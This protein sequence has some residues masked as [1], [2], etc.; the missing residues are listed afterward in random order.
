MP[1]SQSSKA[2]RF[3]ELHHHPGAFLIPNPWDPGSARILAGLGFAALATSSGA[4]AGVHGWRD[5]QLTRDQALAHCRAIAE[6][7]DIPVSGDLENGFGDSPAEIAET[8]RLAAAAGLVGCSIEDFTRNREW[9]IYDL[10]LATERIAAA[11]EAAKSLPF[12]FTLTARAENFV[13]GKTNLDDTI[14]RLQAYEKAGAD[15]LFAPALPDLAAARQICAAVS[16]PVNFMVGIRGKSFTVAELADAGVKRI[17]FASSLYRAAMT[18][19]L[20][21][22]T[23]ARQSGTF[24]YLG[25]TMTTAE[26]VKF[27]PD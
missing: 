18:G 11:A 10:P 21:A 9:P 19:L 16:K 2:L 6:A 20:A 5:G 24:N 27:F 4:A 17:S 14:R 12:R 13:H 15:V 26:L 25:Q 22:A 7:V 3:T 23:E 1:T 8:I